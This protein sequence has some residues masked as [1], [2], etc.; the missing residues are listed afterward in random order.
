MK[1]KGLDLNY[2]FSG[3]LMTFFLAYVIPC[4]HIN[5]WQKIFGFPLG[6]FTV[7]HDTIGDR[8]IDSTLVDVIPFITDSMICYLIILLA[9][10][11]FKKFI[12]KDIDS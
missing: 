11:F 9:V 12:K 3:M 7:Y 8:I 2:L 6:W 5:D 1:S 10:R 4:R